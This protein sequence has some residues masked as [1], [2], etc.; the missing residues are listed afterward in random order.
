MSSKF[1]PGPSQLLSADNFAGHL[2]THHRVD[3]PYY[4]RSSS[5]NHPQSTTS[6][7]IGSRYGDHNS[8]VVTNSGTLTPSTN[9]AFQSQPLPDSNW[10]SATIASTTAALPEQASEDHHR[11]PAPQKHGQHSSYTIP[12]FTPPLTGREGFRTFGSSAQPT[13][14]PA[15]YLSSAPDPLEQ[16]GQQPVSFE[17]YGRLPSS[18]AFTSSNHLPSNNSYRSN[19]F[20]APAVPDNALP[21]PAS[22]TTQHTGGLTA[23]RLGTN[24]KIDDP[25]HSLDLNSD[26]NP[27]PEYAEE[28]RKRMRYM[29]EALAP[30]SHPKDYHGDRGSS[31]SKRDRKG[32]NPPIS[33]HSNHTM[34]SGLPGTFD[35][36]LS[37][38]SNTFSAHST[39]GP[40]QTPYSTAGRFLP[41]QSPP[42][43]SRGDQFINAPGFQTDYPVGGLNIPVR[44]NSAEPFFAEARGIADR[45]HREMSALLARTPS[46]L[47]SQVIKAEDESSTPLEYAR[48][49]IDEVKRV[50]MALHSSSPSLTVNTMSNNKYQGP[51]GPSPINPSPLAPYASQP[52]NPSPMLSGDAWRPGTSQGQT[53]NYASASATAMQGPGT[54]GFHPQNSSA[55]Y[56]NNGQIPSLSGDYPE[57]NRWSQI[58][59]PPTSAFGSADQGSY[60]EVQRTRPTTNLQSGSDHP[61]NLSSTRT[62]NSAVPHAPL[63][64]GVQVGASISPNDRDKGSR[65]KLVEQDGHEKEDSQE[66]ERA[67]NKGYKSRSRRQPNGPWREEEAEKL[68]RLAEESK[69]KN[70]NIAPD[71]IDWDYVVSGFENTRTRHQILIKAVYLGIRPTTTHQS[72]LVRQKQYLGKEQA[73][74]GLTPAKLKQYLDERREE[75]HD[76]EVLGIDK[77]EAAA[78]RKQLKAKRKKAELEA[79]IQAKAENGYIAGMPESTAPTFGGV[80]SNQESTQYPPQAQPQGHWLGHQ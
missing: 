13:E 3:L 6:T 16:S 59:P 32:P 23:G 64:A 48:R 1:L 49:V 38:A 24:T 79:E 56:S 28:S 73:I 17:S 63:P 9:Q 8:Q 10:T 74:P 14:A 80:V 62:P 44:G 58:P 51:Q 7:E 77:E 66:S 22:V 65:R 54:A 15:L 78:R 76:M 46:S 35:N 70:S 55:A 50:S 53:E 40:M 36:P 29:E 30:G 39:G 61:N 45:F 69:G 5:Y 67:D 12:A 2:D 20:P 41:H 31:H 33:I 47:L 52:I 21:F 68:K 27:F 26:M 34:S 11:Y 57:G 60:A 4:P 72:R 43:S 75:E 25:S 37:S 18:A 71:E 19:S 42:T